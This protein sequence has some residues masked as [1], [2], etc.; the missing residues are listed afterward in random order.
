M[1]RLVVLYLY[2]LYEL[3]HHELNTLQLIF[4]SNGYPISFTDLYVK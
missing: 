1:V 4:R 3:S 2:K